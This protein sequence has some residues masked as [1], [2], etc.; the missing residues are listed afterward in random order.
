MNRLLEDRLDFLRS[1][2]DE[3]W[4][5]FDEHLQI[6]LINLTGDT[7]MEKKHPKKMDPLTK[8]VRDK[9]LEFIIREHPLAHDLKFAMAA[10]RVGHDYERMQELCG[11][12]NR[13]VEFLRNTQFR[14]LCRDM[15]GVVADLLNLN[16]LVQGTWKRDN[17]DALPALRVE[18]SALS[19]NIHS[20]ITKLQTRILESMAL[21]SGNAEAYVELVLACR[22]LKRIAGLMASVP[23]EMV[24]FSLNV[25][26]FYCVC[27]QED[28]MLIRFVFVF[29]D[30]CVFG[31]SRGCAGTGGFK[32]RDRRRR[33]R[34]FAH[35]VHS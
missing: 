15:T 22:H 14:E 5:G 25:D 18:V 28:R 9:C 24:A 21:A 35:Q 26:L 1:T 30:G 3:L 17:R 20:V 4:H 23:D 10:L 19:A 32:S 31:S 16:K 12:L 33:F 34:R 7:R 13:R 11:T 6:L 27:K 2:L 29:A 8:S